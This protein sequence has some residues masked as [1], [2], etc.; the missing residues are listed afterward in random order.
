MSYILNIK[1]VFKN[2]FELRHAIVHFASLLNYKCL[3]I[4]VLDTLWLN[5]SMCN[6]QGQYN[7]WFKMTYLFYTKLCTSKT[8]AIS[9]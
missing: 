9:L 5:N 3:N 4:Y 1:Y 2:K 6:T 7:V 8:K